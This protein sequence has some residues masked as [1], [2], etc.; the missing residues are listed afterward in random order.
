MPRSLSTPPAPTSRH[1]QV[2]HMGLKCQTVPWDEKEIR[3]LDAVPVPQ[4]ILVKN[5]TT[6]KQFSVP[7]PV[8]TIF[9]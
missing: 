4:D 1:N 8:L 6:E 9:L 2:L 3:A 5:K 7:K